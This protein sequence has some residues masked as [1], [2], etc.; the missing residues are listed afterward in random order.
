MPKIGI[1]ASWIG[2]HKTG[3]AVYLFEILKKWNKNKFLNHEFIIFRSRIAS[4]LFDEINLDNRFTFYDSPSKKSIRVIWQQFVLP[5][6]ISH[7]SINV[8]WGPSFI[9]PLLTRVPSVL[10]VH[11][12]SFHLYPSVH[13][14][15]KRIYFPFM[16]GLA[17][18]K[19]IKI[20]SI[21][22]TTKED[23]SKIYPEAKHKTVL[24][25]LAA[26]SFSTNHK[27]FNTLNKKFNLTGRQYMVF[28][29]TIEPRK[30]LKR[31]LCA[32]SQICS[33][34]NLDLVIIGLSGWMVKDVIQNFNN[35]SAYKIKYLDYVNDNELVEIIS[36]SYALIYPSLYE[37]FGLPVI[38]AMSLGV[39]VITSN[40]G[41]TKEI[42]G[43]AAILVD[44][45]SVNSI[46]DGILNIVF[47][48]KI[49]DEMI[50]LGHKRAKDF[51]WDFTAQ[52]TIE[53]IEEVLTNRKLG[54]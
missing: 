17:V 47:N 15:I 49:R 53:T 31:L 50:S 6:L 36:S 44:P 54:T 12:L 35:L 5:F 32:W 28:V 16:I 42:A 11:D 27:N 8:H 3:T 13:E 39:P 45:L 52:I 1:D 19:A 14:P 22:E 30:N 40:A 38:E 46:R 25:P 10:T 2:S 21:S 7:K 48:E 4:R 41:A 20:L 26:R 29:G 37:G 43:E 23:L 34:I 51:S 9:L 18:N 33:K 24:T